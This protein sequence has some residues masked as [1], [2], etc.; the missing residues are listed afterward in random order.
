MLPQKLLR[1]AAVSIVAAG[2]GTARAAEPAPVDAKE[3]AAK[4]QYCTS[5]HQRSGQGYVGANPVP[6]LAGQ[7]PEYFEAQLNAFLERRRE[8]NFMFKAPPPT[9]RSTRG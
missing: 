6:R 9:R 1:I 7:Q 8:N 4:L 3:L 5:C 2:V